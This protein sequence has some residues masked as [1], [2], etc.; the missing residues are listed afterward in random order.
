MV[1]ALCISF[2]PNGDGGHHHTPPLKKERKKA[3]EETTGA[4]MAVMS[5]SRLARSALVVRVAISVWVLAECEK[6]FLLYNSVKS[7]PSNKQNSCVS[8]CDRTKYMHMQISKHIYKLC[9]SENQQMTSTRQHGELRSPVKQQ[10]TFP[11][12]IL[13][14]FTIITLPSIFLHSCARVSLPCV[15]LGKKVPPV[16]N[17]HRRTLQKV[18]SNPFRGPP[19]GIHQNHAKLLVLVIANLE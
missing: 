3:Q 6:D 1:A 17:V 10:V 4:S 11:R 14:V 5:G 13:Y 8:L 15:E 7:T 18:A 12:Y 2:R 9:V 16:T 19:T